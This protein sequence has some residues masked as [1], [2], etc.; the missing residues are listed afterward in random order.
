MAKALLFILLCFSSPLI[1]AQEN[2][3]LRDIL[4]LPK[5]DCEKFS[6]QHADNISDFRPD[7]LDSIAKH[8]D[9]WIAD[10]G[11]NEAVFRV[12]ILMSIQDGVLKEEDLGP[13]FEYFLTNYQTRVWESKTSYYQETFELDKEY[14][15]YVPLKSEFDKWTKNWAKK[16]LYTKEWGALEFYFLNI[17]ANDEPYNKDIENSKYDSIKFIQ[18]WRAEKLE[19]SKSATGLNLTVGSWSP[20]GILKEYFDVSPAIGLSITKS[21]DKNFLI[22]LGINFRIPQNKREFRIT[23]LDSSELTSSNL[24]IELYGN[25]AYRVWTY[26]RF[27]IS[28]YIGGGFDL[29]YTGVEKPATNED[30]EPTNYSINTYNINLGLDLNFKT[31]SYNSWG[32]RGE[33]VIM[34]YNR[35]LVA[36]DDLSGNAIRLFLYFRL[37]LG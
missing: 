37:N 15:L 12:F 30:E 5:N 11:Y 3:E 33:Y 7:D 28:P 9:L 13:D 29:L 34:D 17:Y 8:L 2:D 19:E 24:A 14:F 35:G 32:L 18:K 22:D 21:I 25:L 16:L 20:T 23:T 1:L 4:N 27:T 10:C 26:K 6:A 36:S 31:K